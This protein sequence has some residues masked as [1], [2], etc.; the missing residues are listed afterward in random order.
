MPIIT[1]AQSKGGAG[2]S[3]VA[4]ALASEFA[5][6]G[7]TVIILDA[8]RQ[9]SLLRWFREREASGTNHRSIKVEDA[10]AIGDDKIGVAIAEA[11]R[12]ADLVIVD[13]E[14]TA[15]MKTAYA[16]QDSDFV[17]VPTRSSR[18]DLE[19]TV[20]TQVMLERMCRGTPY[21]VLVTQTPSAVRSSAELEIDRQIKNQ[22]P[23][24]DVQMHMLDAFRAMFNYRKSLSEVDA[25]GLA[26]AEKARVIAK[27]ILKQSLQDMTE[28]KAA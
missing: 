18:L 19:R 6:A 21:R 3:T 14:G 8:D 24:F 2:K 4:L 26:R 17:I 12:N 27:T 1:I 22:L 23:T 7:G 10:S 25:E 5:A 28:R 15:N 9:L 13:T 16:A 20:E 11:A